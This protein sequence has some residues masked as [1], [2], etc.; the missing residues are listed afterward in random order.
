MPPPS[1]RPRMHCTVGARQI[2]PVPLGVIQFSH[3]IW[4][5]I[6]T[7]LS[8]AIRGDDPNGSASKALQVSETQRSERS[9]FPAVIAGQ[10]NTNGGSLLFGVQFDADPE[11]ILQAG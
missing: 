8:A 1:E 2:D 9:G 5:G 6:A 4:L 11:S 3:R 10:Q 7:Q